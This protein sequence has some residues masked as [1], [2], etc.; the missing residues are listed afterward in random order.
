MNPLVRIPKGNKMVFMGLVM[1]VSFVACHMGKPSANLVKES[2]I[3]RAYQV[4][5]AVRGKGQI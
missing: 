1:V 3:V 5:P 2:I 4:P